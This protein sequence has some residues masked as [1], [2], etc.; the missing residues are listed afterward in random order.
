MKF[1]CPM[2][3]IAECVGSRISRRIAA[4]SP[5]LTRIKPWP[6]MPKLRLHRNYITS[7]PRHACTRRTRPFASASTHH[8]ASQCVTPLR[9]SKATPPASDPTLHKTKT[10]CIASKWRIARPASANDPRSSWTARMSV[11]RQ[12]RQPRCAPL[13]RAAVGLQQDARVPSQEPGLPASAKGTRTPIVFPAAA[14][15]QP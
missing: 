2:M 14:Q 15:R 8:L 5:L 12:C 11:A 3:Y 1:Q 9:T 7:G 6:V 13:P 10:S 4:L